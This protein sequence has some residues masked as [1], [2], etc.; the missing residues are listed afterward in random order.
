MDT[1]G[2]LEKLAGLSG[3][4]REATQESELVEAQLREASDSRDSSLRLGRLIEARKGELSLLA[5]LRALIKELSE[6][7]GFQ[8]IVNYIRSMREEQKGIIDRVR[9]VVDPAGVEE[10]DE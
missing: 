10:E 8:D 3:R 7:E 4:A 9:K 2:E 6:Y 5:K 1:P